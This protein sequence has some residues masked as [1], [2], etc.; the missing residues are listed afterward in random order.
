MPPSRKWPSTCAGAPVQPQIHLAHGEGRRAIAGLLEKCDA[1]VV[2]LANEERLLARW[3]GLNLGLRLGDAAPCP[4]IYISATPSIPVWNLE[5]V[6]RP[7][8]RA[9]GESVVRG[10]VAVGEGREVATGL[11]SELGL[12]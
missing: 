2:F 8:M 11:L 5:P 4:A 1:D 12:A 6:R 9:A 10:R 3:F 7:R